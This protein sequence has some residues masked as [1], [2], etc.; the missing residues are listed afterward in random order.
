VTVLDTE[1]RQL[2]FTLE[3]AREF[4]SMHPRERAASEWFRYLYED[5]DS[6]S[7]FSGD[8]LRRTTAFG[9]VV[10]AHVAR[11]YLDCAN[12]S[13]IELA[14]TGRQVRAIQARASALEAEIEAAG[15]WLI[16]DAESSEFR[17][18]LRRLRVNPSQLEARTAGRLPLGKRR[19]FVLRLAESPCEMTST[20]PT[21]LLMVATVLGWEETSDRTIREILTKET[22]EAIAARTGANRKAVIASEKEAHSLINRVSVNPNSAG[23]SAADGRSDGEK[24]AD[25]LRLLETLTDRTASTVMVDALAGFA[26]EFGVERVPRD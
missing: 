24:V 12:V 20:I 21:K 26:V 22:R 14:P 8:P 5:R 16:A 2:S 1:N 7:F 15:P 13:E 3:R 9:L 25:A 23:A 10:A 4:L 19:A 11:A 17:G 6:R 18:P